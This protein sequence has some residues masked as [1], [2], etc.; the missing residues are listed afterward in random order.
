MA[1]L[2]SLVFLAVLGGAVFTYAPEDAQGGQWLA[3]ARAAVGLAQTE[4]RE[5]SY[6][7]VGVERGNLHS[8]V[9]ATGPLRPVATVMIGSE[10]SGQV[11]EVYA[12]HNQEVRRG[13]PIALI[14]PT[15]FQIAVAQATAELD[16]ARAA[17]ETQRATI[18]R[19]EA[20]LETARFEHAAA[21]ANADAARAMAEDAAADARRKAALGRSISAA[22][23]ERAEA[24]ELAA[25]A[26]ARSAEALEGA[27]GSLVAQAEA[28][29]AAAQSQLVNAEAVIRQREAALRHADIELERTVI[30]SPVDGVVIGRDAEVGQ[31]VAAALQAPILFTIARDLR[32]MQVNASVDESE[33]GRILPG[34][35]V[36]FT[37]DAYRDR[38]FEG[39]VD[40]I[41]KSPSTSQN[42]VTYTVIV[43]ADN[44][45]LL[46]L[47]GM[48]ASA[49]FVI[50]EA[51][52]VAIAPNAAL[53]FSPP[54]V[55]APAGP[56]VWVE[57][58]GGLRAIPVEVGLTDE[59][60][61]EIRGDGIAP[62]L[63]VVTGIERPREER[64]TA[65]I[66]LG[67]F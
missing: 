14:D 42:V 11:K 9:H 18:R 64:S 63:R 13:E 30:R 55:A 22:E 15:S 46:L 24:A 16:I 43:K 27:R 57:E 7:T 54:D 28:E 59:A 44:P 29:L 60:R 40:Q 21:R 8:V 51:R 4:V 53:R 48:T 62:G 32:D 20:A 23:R 26:Q 50:A 25:L 65:R 5:L 1:K 34:Q 35:R 31:T 17:A 58:P 6:R 56:H 19:V 2:F 41:R 3:E 38:R 36:E 66:L 10:V 45:D 61:T 47:P 12:D 49:R 52:D 33:I 37:V 67:G 39:R